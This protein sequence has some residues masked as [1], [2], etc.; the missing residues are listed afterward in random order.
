PGETGVVNWGG[1]GPM[2]FDSVELDGANIGAT[3]FL[4]NNTNGGALKWT[5]CY[6]HGLPYSAAISFYKSPGTHTI[7]GFKVDNCRTAFNHES[8]GSDTTVNYISPRIGA[9]TRTRSGCG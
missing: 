4:V 9:I 7:T 2:T 6:V 3:G 5:N 1:G 8:N